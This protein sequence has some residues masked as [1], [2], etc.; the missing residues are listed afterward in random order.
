M[1]RPFKATATTFRTTTWGLSIVS[2]LTFTLSLTGAGCKERPASQPPDL[3]RQAQQVA[4]DVSAKVT[5]LI[6]VA[7]DKLRDAGQRLRTATAEQTAKA[8][9]DARAALGTLEQNL[10]EQTRAGADK[11][12]EGAQAGNETAKR[13]ITELAQS[14]RA[15][16][17]RLSSEAGPAAEKT[18]QEIASGLDRLQAK[19]KELKDKSF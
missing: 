19:L 17:D 13:E 1:P 11:V 5:S 15:G 12:K 3:E 10:R 18:R 8:A 16:L 4:N 6:D 9:D 2:L 14:V 7:S